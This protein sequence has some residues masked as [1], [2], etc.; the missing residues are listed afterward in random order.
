MKLHF[1]AWDFVVA[2]PAGFL[3]FMGTVMFSTL[4]GLLIGKVPAIAELVVL[5]L[6]AMLT[7]ILAGLTRSTQGPETA[8]A[9]AVVADL[10]ILFLWFNVRLGETYN[11]LVIGLPGIILVPL[12]SFSGSILGF[13]LRKPKKL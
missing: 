4:L 10:I 8:L 7:G 13:R 2:L 3:I 5:V 6:F 11:P 9:A 1:T 12:F